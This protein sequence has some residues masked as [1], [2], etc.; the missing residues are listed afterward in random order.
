MALPGRPPYTLEW[1][2][3]ASQVEGANQM[4]EILFRALRLLGVDVS[5]LVAAGNTSGTGSGLTHAQITARILLDQDRASLA[6]TGLTGPTG[7]TGPTGSTGSKGVAGTS[8]PG[9]MGEDGEDGITLGLNTGTNGLAPTVM[10]CLSWKTQS[11]G[12]TYQA[13]SDGF[14]IAYS[15][16]TSGLGSSLTGY[17]DTANP[18]TT[19]RG[20]NYPAALNGVGSFMMPVKYGEF[21]LVTTTIVSG[22]GSATEAMYWVPL[23]TAG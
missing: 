1:P 8:T 14:V 15:I 13:A 6:P 20:G 7:P 21:Y 22:T 4:F 23:G 3:T 17:S 19:I 2:L 16:T 12:S 11:I 10:R 18:P 5:T 9:M